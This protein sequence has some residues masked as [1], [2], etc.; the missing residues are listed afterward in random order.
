L[1]A[2]ISCNKDEDNKKSGMELMTQRA[3]IL[4]SYGYD[5]NGNQQIDPSENNIQP[6]EQDNNYVFRSNGS[7]R[8]SD[9]GL[10]CGGPSD[11]E[12]N[13]RF[14]NHD[15]Q[16]E[17]G[18]NIISILALDEQQLVIGNKMQNINGDSTLYMNV[19][20]H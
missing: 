20:R 15:T 2:L 9:L 16:L 19:Y 14:I 10:L 18:I 7:G 3:W 4:S 13:W 5:N 1:I 11:H 12:F 17:L 8:F 6:C